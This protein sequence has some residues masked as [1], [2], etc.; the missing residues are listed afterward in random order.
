MCIDWI[1]HITPKGEPR[2]QFDLEDYAYSISNGG[3][4]RNMRDFFTLS[5]ARRQFRNRLRY[6]VARWSYSRH[7]LAWELWNEINAVDRDVSSD[8]PLLTGW[9]KEMCAYLKSIDPAKHLTTNSLGSSGFWPEMWELPEN[10]FAQTHN[11]YGW[12]RAED[13][14]LAHDMAGF[15]LKWLEPVR[16]F[17]KPYLFT[18]FGVIREK[19]DFRVLC[20][21]DSE[22]VHLHNGLWA[23]LAHGAAGT[24][25]LWWWGQYVD[26]KNLYFHFLPVA[27]FTADIPWTSEGFQ[28]A[29]VKADHPRVRALGLRGRTMSILWVQNADH[30]WWNVVHKK[31]IP[32]IEGARL[33]LAGCPQ[34]RYRVEYWDTWTGVVTRET[35][36][37]S[38]RGEIELALPRLE[39]DAA[40]K[41][42]RLN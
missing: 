23:P 27:R 18:E 11:Y 32:A 36:L 14:E 6:T 38:S 3:P 33:T 10:D 39:R 24:G 31:P 29:A 9:N 28:Q 20:D 13:E 5:E 25:H 2:R 37:R 4:C 21:R 42:V 8:R 16:H 34:G 40:L 35:D 41:V 19:P 26:P 7:V 30:T 22:G 17:R 15:A 1:R 12:H